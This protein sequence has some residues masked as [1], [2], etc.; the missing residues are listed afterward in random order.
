[1]ARTVVFVEKKTNI[2][3]FSDFPQVKMSSSELDM[4]ILIVCCAMKM[5]N[6]S[7]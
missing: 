4:F 3:S 1:M 2:V 6:E 7:A 5:D